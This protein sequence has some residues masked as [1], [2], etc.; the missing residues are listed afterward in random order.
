M[1][2]VWRYTP[3]RAQDTLVLKCLDDT[4]THTHTHTYTHGSAPLTEGT[5]GIPGCYLHNTQ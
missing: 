2:Y 5:A 1:Y 4:Q 3:P